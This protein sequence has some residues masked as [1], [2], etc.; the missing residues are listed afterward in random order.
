MKIRSVQVYPL[1]TQPHGEHGLVRVDTDEG[2]SGWGSCYTTGD[3]VKSA[4]KDLSPL[5]IGESALEP[6]RLTE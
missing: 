2:L 6:E 4:L 1:E 3:L 5:I